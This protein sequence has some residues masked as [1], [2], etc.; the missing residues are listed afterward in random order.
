MDKKKLLNNLKSSGFVNIGAVLSSKEVI[1]LSILSK[2]AFEEEREKNQKGIKSSNYIPKNSGTEGL[3]FLPQYNL[4]IA[5]LID[6]TL[7]S[8]SV[9]FVLKNV[10]GPSYKIWH[11]NFRRSSPNDRGLYI[12]Q[13]A[14]GETNLCILLSDNKKGSGATVFLKESHLV[15]TTMKQWEIELPPIMLKWLRFIFTPLTGKAGDVAFFFNRTWHG[16]FRNNENHCF[17]VILISFLPAECVYSFEIYGSWS[18]EFIKSTK[19]MLLGK[20]VDPL[21]GTKILADGKYKILK[22]KKGKKVILPYALKISNKNYFK[23]NFGSN[24][25]L[26]LKIIFLRLI[27]LFLRPFY[28]LIKNKI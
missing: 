15:K 4:R 2:K 6:K 18:P 26:T 24:I 16:R 20:L 19:G 8:K 13:D 9:S 7:K 23:D 22:K 3:L 28:I 17:D 14:P 25:K 21:V 5:Q 12:H 1:E 27:F 10:L 11:I